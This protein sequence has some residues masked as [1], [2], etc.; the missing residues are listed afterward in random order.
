MLVLISN[1]DCS[2]EH[3]LNLKLACIIPGRLKER[4][5][6]PNLTITAVSEQDVIMAFEHEEL[7]VAG[8]QFHPESILSMH[9]KKNC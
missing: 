2:A 1:H 4:T 7:P 3:R 8:V 9:G 5:F 6:P